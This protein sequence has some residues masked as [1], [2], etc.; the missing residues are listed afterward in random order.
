[1]FGSIQHRLRRIC[2]EQTV[3]YSSLEGDLADGNAAGDL[4]TI[5]LP[6]GVFCCIV[7]IKP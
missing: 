7:T 4:K 5:L 3:Q 1:M 6:S 2:W